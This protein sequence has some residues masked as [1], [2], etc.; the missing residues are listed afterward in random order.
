MLNLT[1]TNYNYTHTI[2][3]VPESADTVLGKLR[4]ADKHS[5]IITLENLKGH[6]LPSKTVVILIKIGTRA[7]KNITRSN[8]EIRTR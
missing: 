7:T 1:C 8:D 3:K 4:T 2:L 6:N 5:H